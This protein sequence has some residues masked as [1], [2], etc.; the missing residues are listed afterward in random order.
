L[1]KLINEVEIKDQCRTLFGFVK[2]IVENVKESDEEDLKRIAPKKDSD[3]VVPRV[4]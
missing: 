3:Y 4:D 2:Y 1:N